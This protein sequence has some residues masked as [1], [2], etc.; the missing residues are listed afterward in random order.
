M[1]A[2]TLPGFRTGRLLWLLLGGGLAER[3]TF[4]PNKFHVPCDGSNWMVKL[5]RAGLEGTNPVRVNR[6]PASVGL[7]ESC[8]P[9][10]SEG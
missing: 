2:A 9:T 8:G 4:R 3:V 5:I 10:T 7:L 6:P 1:P